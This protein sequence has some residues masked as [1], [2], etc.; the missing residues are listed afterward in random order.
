MPPTTTAAVSSGTAAQHGGTYQLWTAKGRLRH[1]PKAPEDS[2]TF[3]PRD[4]QDGW[5]NEWLPEELKK[6]S[7]D[8]T[9][10]ERVPKLRNDFCWEGSEFNPLLIYT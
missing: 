9:G 8:Y 1:D 2:Y 3:E 7:R 10:L 6:E 4:Q 5:V